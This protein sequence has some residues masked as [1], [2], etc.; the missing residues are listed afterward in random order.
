MGEKNKGK[1]SGRWD[2]GR[3]GLRREKDMGGQS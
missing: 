1:G 2:E 3:T